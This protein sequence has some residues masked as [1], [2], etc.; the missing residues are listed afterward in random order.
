MNEETSEQVSQDVSPVPFLPSFWNRMLYA[1]FIIA[2]PIFN[3]TFVDVLKPDW[4]SG[5]TSDYINL[6]LSPQASLF[7][8]PLLAYSIFC[9]ILLL[10]D[11]GRYA[12]SFAVRFG[13]YTG[14]FL[15][16]QYSLLTT[17][18]MD[19]A[20][21]ALLVVLAYFSPIIVS[22][23]YLWL[24]SK[25]NASLVGNVS[26][27]LGIVILFISMIIIGSVFSPFIFLAFFFGI[28]APF[29]S[30]LISGQAALW[31]LKNHENK[32]TILRGFGLAAWSA[33]YA[34]ALRF[35]ILK[36]YELYAA[37]P[38]QP[39]DCYIATAAA[40]GHPRFV[41]SRRINLSKGKQMMVNPQLQRLKLAELA[42]QA[43]IPGLHK[44]VRRIYDVVG[45]ILA[46]KINN[47]Y[48]A[49]ASY[50]LLKP[51][52]WISFGILSWLLPEA[53]QIASKIYIE[54]RKQ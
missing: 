19:T 38:P 22:K 28:A 39:Y 6:F 10:W 48:L 40:Q 35:D 23:L 34:Y 5:K 47:P 16:L 18:A 33:S 42:L 31:L 36:M 43:A 37:L 3:F 50:L 7:F 25:W 8:F 14:A 32:F 12:K 26:L 24:A 21:S 2:A 51:F 9:Y 27:G 41:G 29:W 53:G 46:R 44:I 15:S 11:S 45:K 49:D 1:A 20:F 13:V 52:E 4:Q 30:F 54:N 17:F